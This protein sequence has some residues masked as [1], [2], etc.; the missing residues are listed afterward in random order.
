MATEF[1]QGVLVSTM[2]SRM[3]LHSELRCYDIGAKEELLCFWHEDQE[4]PAVAAFA[5]VLEQVHQ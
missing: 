1:G 3:S 5:S 2:L 4:N